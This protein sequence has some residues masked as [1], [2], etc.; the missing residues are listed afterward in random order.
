MT[1]NPYPHQLEQKLPKEM[2]YLRAMSGSW[3]K[4]QAVLDDVQHA[5]GT[6]KCMHLSSRKGGWSYQQQ[7]A[8]YSNKRRILASE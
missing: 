8:K 2:G 5:T 1:R 4:D 7:G 3:P 6:N